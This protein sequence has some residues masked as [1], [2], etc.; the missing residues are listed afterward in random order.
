MSDLAQAA[1]QLRLF[2]KNYEAAALVIPA[3]D[4][5]GSLD[6]AI[7][8]KRRLA[9]A[10][11]ARLEDIEQKIVGANLDLETCRQDAAAVVDQA[12]AEA[13]ELVAKAKAEAGEIAAAAKAAQ[14]TADVALDEAVKARD[15]A[16]EE[17]KAAEDRRDQ[18]N[19]EIEAS[20]AA[21]RARLG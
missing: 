17:A 8:D 5:L 10:E 4:Q 12:K 13:A 20:L 7:A 21:A 16:L 6:N 15:A 9:D 2:F 19:A 11:Q 18:V 3:L 1:D 14:L